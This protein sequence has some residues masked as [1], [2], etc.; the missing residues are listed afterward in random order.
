MRSITP[1]DTICITGMGMVTSLG[2]DAA[3]SCAAAR[4]GLT[5]LSEPKTLNYIDDQRWGS[6]PMVGHIVPVIANGFVG[7]AKA[8]M[9]GGYALKDLLAR[10]KIFKDELNYTGI[11]INL[12]DQF[13]L[14]THAIAERE[15][16]EQLS[17]AY[18]STEGEEIEDAEEYDEGI[19]DANE[20]DENN[21]MEEPSEEWILPSSRWKEECSSFIPRLLASCEIT[22]RPPT[23]IFILAIIQGL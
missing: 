12:S 5:R 2:L 13:L 21:E 9:L 16:M 1:T 6:E 23:T 20:Y 14:D 19:E 7:I 10:R 17:K 4:A 11:Y 3:N 15:E 22:V 8:L 18:A